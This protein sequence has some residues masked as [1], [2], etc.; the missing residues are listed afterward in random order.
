MAFYGKWIR[1][2]KALKTL[3]GSIKVG[4]LIFRSILAIKNAKQIC[5]KGLKIRKLF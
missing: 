5:K 1:L 2:L 3:M 4:F